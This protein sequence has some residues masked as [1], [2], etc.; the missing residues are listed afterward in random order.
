LIP[1][2]VEPHSTHTVSRA[3]QTCLTGAVTTKRTLAWSLL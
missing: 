2:Y 3:A 1:K